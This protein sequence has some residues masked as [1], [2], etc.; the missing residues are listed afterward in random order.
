MGQQIRIKVTARR[1][2]DIRLYAQALIALARQLQEE[3]EQREQGTRSGLPSA[4]D[5]GVAHG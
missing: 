2:P 5:G 1:E 3:K 4:G